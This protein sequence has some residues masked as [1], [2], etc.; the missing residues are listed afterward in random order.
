MEERSLADHR[1]PLKFTEG[2]Y[3][4]NPVA[5]H[6]VPG[7]VVKFPDCARMPSGPRN[8]RLPMK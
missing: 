2:W 5:L 6:H 3:R 7:V 4:R 8:K 1:R